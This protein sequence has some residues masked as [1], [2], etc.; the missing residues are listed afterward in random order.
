MRVRNERT[1]KEMRTNLRGQIFCFAIFHVKV[2]LQD[3]DCL[4][5]NVF[6]AVV[7]ELLNLV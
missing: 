5:V 6:V 7:L 2:G 1:P 3:E 4:I